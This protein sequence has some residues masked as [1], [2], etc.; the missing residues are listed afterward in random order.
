MLFSFHSSK[1]KLNFLLENVI[2]D[3]GGGLDKRQIL[4]HCIWMATKAIKFGWIKYL[5]K[6]GD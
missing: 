6:F 4:W 1:S 5:E 2:Q 3:Y